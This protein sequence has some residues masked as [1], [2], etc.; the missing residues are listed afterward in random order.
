MKPPTWTN[1]VRSTKVLGVLKGGL[2][3]GRDSRICNLAFLK[4]KMG[5]PWFPP[6]DWWS[7]LRPLRQ[8]GHL[9]AGRSA[10]ETW[11]APKIHG[12]NGEHTLTPDLHRFIYLCYSYLFFSLF[13]S[14]IPMNRKVMFRRFWSRSEQ[15]QCSDNVVTIVVIILNV[16]WMLYIN[17]YIY[18]ILHH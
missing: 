14:I 13:V 2:L 7:T 11:S 12:G 5:F 3:G 8:A 4:F 6:S 16:I 17:V 10:V 9:T 15:W 1:P 18:Y